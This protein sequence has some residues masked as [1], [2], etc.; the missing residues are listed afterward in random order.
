MK[1][2]FEI[3]TAG[4]GGQGLVFLASFI[5]QAIMLCGKNVAQTQSYGTAQRGGFISAEVVADD[6][7]ILF[8]QVTEPDI[9]IA[10]HEVV[11]TRYDTVKAPVLYDSDL[12]KKEGFANWHGLPFARIAREIG[13]P[14][15]AN[16]VAVGGMLAFL[17]DLD[18]TYFEEAAR[19]RN[20]ATAEEGICAIR[21]GLEIAQQSRG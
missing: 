8:Q 11:G 5:S 13:S 14:R 15:S 17:P 1:K 7:E 12:I 10:L 4:T 3:L 16:L 9:I 2:H 20:P 6:G 19:Q 18:V 21:R